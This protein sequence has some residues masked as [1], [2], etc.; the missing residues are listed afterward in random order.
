MVWIAYTNPGHPLAVACL[1][2]VEAHRAAHGEAPEVLF[3]EN[4]GRFV[5]SDS[6]K[7]AVSLTKAIVDDCEKLYE[8][9]RDKSAR[10]SAVAGGVS[11]EQLDDVIVELRRALVQSGSPSRLVEF[12]P[13]DT[14]R[15]LL[16]R[17]DAGKLL[18]I[19]STPDA[20]VYCLAYPLVLPSR[21]LGKIAVAVKKYIAAYGEAP[22]TVLAPGQGFLAIGDSVK[23]I[24]T[25][26]VVFQAELG[27]KLRSAA[28]GGAKRLTRQNVD[29]I[30]GWEVEHYR[31]EL[32]RAEAGAPGPLTGKVALVTGAGSGLGRGIAMGLASAGAHVVLA[33]IDLPGAEET[34]GLIRQACGTVR[35]AAVKT[36]V[37]DEV[38]MAGAF[39]RAV[40]QFGGLDV[41]VAAAG[42]APAYPI[43]D[44]P[45]GAFRKTLEINLT[46]YFLAAREAARWMIRQG[47]GGSLIFISS[48]SGIG[49]SRNN[50][51]YNVTKAGELHLMRGLA[52][53][54][55]RHGIRSNAI[56]PGNVF[57]GSKIWNPEY[58][59]QA[60]K[61]R[62]LKPEQVIPYYVSLTAMNQEIK[63]QDIADA[64]VFLASDQSRV[65][66]GQSL[67][68]DG[69]QEFVR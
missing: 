33:D 12:V 23:A 57:E 31:R 28:L 40:R 20:M 45:V 36:D 7:R 2:A 68:V 62:G 47:T 69:G 63:Q 11:N 19:N 65:V 4:H 43:E 17:P 16:A 27:T 8:S 34:A 30:N 55:G 1:K 53:E 14:A 22:R 26:T 60:A 48:K 42:I 18:A 66:S 35:A 39:G 54:L 41:L 21:P 38:S 51:A 64:A 25:T 61:K 58:I 49:A 52:L 67:V 50:A 46:G 24:R 44:F 37:T 10:A 56:C 32:A 59:R 5:T 29:Y 3:L 15:E 9:R 13:D 6:A